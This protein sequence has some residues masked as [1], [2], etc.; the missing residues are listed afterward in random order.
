[1]DITITL[2]DEQGAIIKDEIQKYAETLAND[3][4][5]QK[6]EREKT[7]YMKVLLA[8]TPEEIKAAAAP[9]IAAEK[10]KLEEAPIKEG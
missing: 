2:T 9:I 10:A 6:A 3:R 4:L 8:K 1:M 7:A 5:A